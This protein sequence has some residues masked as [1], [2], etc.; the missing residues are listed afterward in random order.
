MTRRAEHAAAPDDENPAGRPAGAVM[1]VTMGAEMARHEDRRAAAAPTLIRGFL[2]SFAVLLFAAVQAGALEG[3]PVPPDTPAIDL[4]GLAER[5]DQASD[6]IQVSTAPGPDGLVR[7]IEVRAQEPGSSSAWAVFALTNETD[8]QIDRLLV[9][10][11]HRLVKS[12]V[13]W[14]DLGASRI[15]TITPSRGFRPERQPSQNADVFLITLDPGATVTFVA[16]LRVPTLPQL[17][18]WQPDAYKDEI[19]NLTFF[20]GILIGIAGMLAVLLTTMFVVRGTLIFPAAAAFAWAVLAYLTI[21]F[22]YWH[23]IFRLQMENDQTY[24]AGAEAMLA[25]ALL[26]FLFAYLNLNRWHVRLSHAGA[27]WLLGLL[28]L[29]ALAVFQAPVA[30]GIARISLAAVGL[31]GF[32]LIV[33]LA[34]RGFDRAIMLI[35]TWLILLVWLFGAAVTVTGHLAE[36]YVSPALAA[37]LVLIVLLITVTVMQYAFSGGAAM[38]VRETDIGRKALALS[39]CGDAVWDWNID[40]DFIFTGHEAEKTLGLKRGT[41]NGSS[42]NWLR[43]VHPA[44]RETF[45]AAL[46]ATVNRRGGR[47][48]EDVRMVCED[49][50]YSWMRV[51]ARPV[52]DREGEIIRCVGTIADVSE[53]RTAQERLL[54]DALHDRLTGL[55]NRELLLDRLDSTITRARTEE[56]GRPTVFVIDLDRFRKV[57]E[58][59]GP[60]VGDTILLTVARRLGRN[61]KPQDTL[62]RMVGDQFAIILLSERE[63]K[64]IAAFA[65]TI[66]RALKAPITFAEREIFLT[67]SIGIAVYD[68]SQKNAETMVKQAEVAMHQAKREGPDAVQAFKPGMKTATADTLTLEAE[69]RRAIERKEI[70]VYYQ[71]IMRLV[72]FSV[73]GFEALV[74][75]DHPR[76]GRLNPDRFIGIAEE[77]GLIVD[78]GLFVLEHAAGQL[79]TWQEELGKDR[80]IFVSVNVSSRQLLRHDLLND[81]RALMGRSHVV[82]GSFKLEVTESLVMENPEYA[83][84]VLTRLRDLGA[85]LSLDDFGTG[86]SS[87]SYL[88]RFPF[89]TI[90]VDKSLV[91][92]N[93]N[94]ARP[95]ILRSIVAMAHDLGMEV[96]AEGAESDDDAH[97]LFELGCEY[98][99][100]YFFGEPMNGREARKFLLQSAD[101][102]VA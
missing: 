12:G 80:P 81:I 6:R 39:G 60:S 19:R 2:L 4:T 76:L 62:A 69:L 64:R 94:G 37:G 93:G 9:A 88:Q 11:F 28:A 35:P 41:L 55:P 30:A 68:G 84:G 15:A 29:V 66:R 40:R 61:V 20:R 58:S 72:D 98:A 46:N 101:E 13:F 27:L 52:L 85:G 32:G 33:Y 1:S 92:V 78:L 83:A 74:R 96:V 49:G 22:G 67:A 16:E 5:I 17:Y 48:V 65:E 36:D 70:Q 31:V 89:D 51:R 47:I 57:N 50:R 10:D 21:D 97:D 42:R 71:P 79:A 3:I 73:A 14:P 7:R 99:Q 53:E 77:T 63:P 23:Q 25:A 26:I 38:V 91:Q 90:K 86:Y 8:E 102:E 18:L 82:P 24:R 34:F 59:V 45:F 44:D 95:I 100:G 56:G 75:W 87:L 54:H 43:H